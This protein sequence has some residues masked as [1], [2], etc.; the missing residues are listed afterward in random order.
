M[1]VAVA[2]VF[3]SLAESALACT[4]DHTN[5]MIDFA[6]SSR[7]AFLEPVCSLHIIKKIRLI[8]D[9]H[10]AK[11]SNFSRNTFN[12]SIAPL[13]PR[14]RKMKCASHLPSHFFLFF[15]FF[16]FLALQFQTFSISVSH[17][18]THLAPVSLLLSIGENGSSSS[19][20]SSFYSSQRCS[21]T[22]TTSHFALLTL[23]RVLCMSL[24]RWPPMREAAEEWTPSG[25]KT[26]RE[27]R[28]ETHS[29]LVQFAKIP[30]KQC[31]PS[32]MYL[33]N[34]FSI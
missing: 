6:V 1:A 30:A 14:R 34:F 2:T 10:L 20:S 15:W 11:Q 29:A 13:L 24:A 18:Q 19:S 8:A 21:I 3:F 17:P 32:R 5:Q 12:F 7:T 27:R 23:S 33:F 22:F 4:R 28:V 26:E 31:D 9:K 25:R 16:S